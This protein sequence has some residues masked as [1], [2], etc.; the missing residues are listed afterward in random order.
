MD[1]SISS[2][3]PLPLR[4]DSWPSELP[5][6]KS[7]QSISAN[8]V[9][10][11]GSDG[12]F[13]SVLVA[14]PL[15]HGSYP[16]S[17]GLTNLP[18]AAASISK[19]M[20]EVFIGENTIRANLLLN[21]TDD[22]EA[23]VE[24]VKALL[25]RVSND[26]DTD[27]DWK[28]LDLF[29]MDTIASRIPR[30]TTLSMDD[31]TIMAIV[32]KLLARAISTNEVET[33]KMLI[34]LRS[35]VDCPITVGGM[36]G[37]PLQIAAYL[38]RVAL[39]RIF[40]NAGADVN[41]TF[42]GRDPLLISCAS[43]FDHRVALQLV[44]ALFSV[45]GLER[46]AVRLNMALLSSASQ[47]NLDA[48][49]FLLHQGADPYFCIDADDKTPY[50]KVGLLVQALNHWARGE[51]NSGYNLVQYLLRPGLEEGAWRGMPPARIPP[52]AMI[53]ACC[54]GNGA[55]LEVLLDHGVD[56]EARNA[57]GFSPLS[58]AIY[59][60]Q[61]HILKILID[62]GVNMDTLT[63]PRPLDQPH[64]LHS[65]ARDGHI[66]RLRVL[67]PL[68]H[69]TSEPL[70][71]GWGKRPSLLHLAAANGRVGVLDLV[72]QHSS[73]INVDHPIDLSEDSDW[74]ASAMHYYLCHQGYLSLRRSRTPFQ[75]ALTARKY[76]CAI[77]L[78]QLGATIDKDG[79]DL[80]MAVRSANLPLIKE[81]LST[82]GNLGNHT[83]V[84]E[85]VGQI[86]QREKQ[87]EIV[88]LVLGKPPSPVRSRVQ[89]F[90]MDGAESWCWR[91][92][93]LLEAIQDED[94]PAVKQIFLKSRR[95]YD[96]QTLCKV[97]EAWSD[98]CPIDFPWVV[99]TLLKNRQPERRSNVIEG[100]VVALA[101]LKGNLELVSLLLKHIPTP[102]RCILPYESMHKALG[103]S[104]RE[105]LWWDLIERD[106]QFSYWD[107]PLRTSPLLMG[108]KGGSE[109]V[110]RKLLD[111]GLAPD[112]V[113]LTAT[114]LSKN[115]SLAGM[116]EEMMQNG[117]CTRGKL[118]RR[119]LTPLQAAVKIQNSELA[120]RLIDY[121][122]DVNARPGGMLHEYDWSNEVSEPRTALQGAVENENLGLIRI[123][124]DA[125]ADANDK[126]A[127]NAGAT[128]LQLAAMKG[129]LGIARLLLDRGADVNARRS[130]GYGRTAL[131]GAAERGRVDMVQWLLSNGAEI[132]GKGRRQYI[133]AVKFA[134][135]EGH[136]AVERLLTQQRDWTEEDLKLLEEE[137][138]DERLYDV[139]EWP[140]PDEY[141]EYERDSEGDE[142]DTASVAEWYDSKEYYGEE[143]E[144]GTD[145]EADSKEMGEGASSEAD[146]EEADGG[147]AGGQEV[148]GAPPGLSDREFLIAFKSSEPKL[149]RG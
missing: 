116:A 118:V 55:V 41:T 15:R 81:I 114:I 64:P 129:L 143:A 10:P 76:S 39:A 45:Q 85:L 121:G 108:V 105:G 104:E 4:F 7:Q 91:G 74:T 32:D 82:G 47:C 75:V 18:H 135:N 124:L 110:V 56:I 80:P 13:S 84:R 40:I 65:A 43:G 22:C 14:N 113:V 59:H 28:V 46:N 72:L 95:L 132:E 21:G 101:S 33:A 89:K 3:A 49:K 126:A 140:D 117:A 1:L 83:I 92:G 138:L 106:P 98:G 123:L 71:S 128:A 38:R 103:D 125:G 19:F 122:A 115:K 87:R 23:G 30:G 131:E 2:P 79:N 29:R 57:K 127:P 96:S 69:G 102:S 120:K 9:A 62:H 44:T 52:D 51:K 148:D 90:L 109:S 88:E 111:A 94:M 149:S 99:E 70:F 144:E 145:S 6:L 119:M 24:V 25:F 50:S 5:W 42:G 66:S 136:H 97:V 54:T 134:R 133:R 77:R 100:T 34:P 58:V 27:E 146:G 147:E 37:T 93:I 31:L 35:D 139:E 130:Q 16:A 17:R 53:A 12:V 137:D 73:V 60:H 141:E 67:L 86:A 68:C 61:C 8:Q 48:L 142:P 36:H 107:Q 26:L 11:T 78:L 112:Q 63:V 20:P